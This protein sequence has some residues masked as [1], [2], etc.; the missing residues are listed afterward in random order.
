M[1]I[2]HIGFVVEDMQAGIN[3][4]ATSYGFRIEN[5]PLYDSAQHVRLAMLSSFNGYRVELIQPV[6]EKS[7]SYDFMKKGGGL[8]HFCYRVADMDATIRRMKQCGHMLFKRPIEA[9]L[10]GG[11]KVAFLYSKKDKQIVELVES[12]DK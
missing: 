7:P 11:K 1:D 6:D 10:F 2:D 3:H 9:V 4:F 12:E 5:E 8:H